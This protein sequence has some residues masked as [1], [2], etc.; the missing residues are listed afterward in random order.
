MPAPFRDLRHLPET[1]R[2]GAGAVEKAA[3]DR[4]FLE[5]QV[6]GFRR[7]FCLSPAEVRPAWFV[8]L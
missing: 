3:G 4:P 6:A 2:Q 5:G 1:L 7:G 8:L